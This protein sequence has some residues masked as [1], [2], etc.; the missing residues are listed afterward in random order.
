VERAEW[1]EVCRVVGGLVIGAALLASPWGLW[2]FVVHVLG[3]D[4]RTSYIRCYEDGVC[5]DDPRWTATHHDE[6]AAYPIRGVQ[7][8]R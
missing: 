8:Q 3:R 7:Q 1:D 5:V 4:S 6:A 2:K